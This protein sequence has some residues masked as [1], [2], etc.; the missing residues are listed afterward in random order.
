MI[1]LYRSKFRFS[2]EQIDNILNNVDKG[3]RKSFASID[4]RALK[5]WNRAVKNCI[6]DTLRKQLDKPAKQYP[7]YGVAAGFL[8]DG[9]E[10]IVQIKNEDARYTSRGIYRTSEYTLKFNRKQKLKAEMIS[11]GF[12]KFMPRISAIKRWIDTKQRKGL[13]VWDD[14]YHSKNNL[15]RAF[16]IA[17]GAVR[18][19]MG[20][21]KP[22]WYEIFDRRTRAGR[23]FQTCINKRKKYHMQ[24]ILDAVLKGNK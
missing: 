21:R 4:K 17:Y 7:R 3:I 1:A 9:I 23:N 5:S 10:K 2:K 20:G 18:K 16:T 14:R 8:Y 11:V 13:W 15:Q 12:G 19:N 6:I 22:K 24:K